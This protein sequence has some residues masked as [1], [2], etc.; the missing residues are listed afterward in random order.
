MIWVRKKYGFFESFG[1]AI[2]FGVEMIILGNHLLGEGL[3]GGKFFL[4]YHLNLY[5]RLLFHIDIVV[6]LI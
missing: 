4:L 2:Q 3:E 1:K 6:L 5:Y